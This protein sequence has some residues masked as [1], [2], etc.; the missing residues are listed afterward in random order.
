MRAMA[1]MG[2]AKKAIKLDSESQSYV[3][4][5]TDSSLTRASFMRF[6]KKKETKAYETLVSRSSKKDGRDDAL[7]RDYALNV[8]IAYLIE[9]MAGPE[10]IFKR[11][12][13]L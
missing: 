10:G 13:D 3:I 4:N 11:Y 9:V 6:F 1:N 5:W 12:G 8:L 7:N 2:M